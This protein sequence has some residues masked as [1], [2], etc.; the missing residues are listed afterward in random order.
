MKLLL[1]LSPGLEP[2]PTANILVFDWDRQEV[3]DRYEYTHQVFSKSHKGI[4]GGSWFRDGLLVV[5]EVQCLE[6]GVAPLRLRRDVS[7]PFLN[8]AHHVM[9][10]E[11]A[12]YVAN[13]GLDTV[14]ELDF[15]LQPRRTHFLTERHGRQ[16]KA[17]FDLL[18]HDLAKSFKR[19]IGYYAQYVHLTRRPAFRNLR[20]FF[21]PRQF[22]AGNQDLRFHDFRPHMLH[23]NHV[24]AVADDV[25]VT[26]WQL[27][28]VVSL[29]TGRVLAQQLGHP[30]DGVVAGDRF[31]VTD[32]WDNR[33]FVHEFDREQKTVG[34]RLAEV[35]VTQRR[36]EGFLRGVAADD[37]YVYVG[38]TARRGSQE[39]SARVR[40]LELETWKP[41]GE[42]RVPGE[43][44]RHIFTVLDA[45]QKYENWNPAGG[46]L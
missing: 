19:M 14:E 16:F 45:T 1:T 40:A 38:L 42:W 9:A 17:M 26:L 15:E 23:P 22:R 4:A 24:T 7:L 37:R 43:F 32:C 3:I 36:Q 10:S 33:L 44:G 28:Q 34:R 12:I 27:G 21:F 13:S 18:K 41:A 30:H 46:A 35:A 39:K 2:A 29:K 11:E 25:W 20:K 8:D 31:Y 5:T 6:F